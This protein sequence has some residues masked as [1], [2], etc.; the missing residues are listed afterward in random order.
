[1]PSRS[2]PRDQLQV[3]PVVDV[4]LRVLGVQDQEGGVVPPV[5]G[6]LTRTGRHH[7]LPRRRPAAMQVEVADVDDLGAFAQG[8]DV[9]GYH[10]WS[11]LDN[12]EWAEDYQMRFG[13]FEVNYPTQE[14]RLRDGSRAYV[15]IVNRF[16]NQA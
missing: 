10:Y 2:Y 16:S 4:D 11:L 7:V 13:L 3:E 1:M 12:F 6:R 14:R 15:G 8:C 5:A 9:R